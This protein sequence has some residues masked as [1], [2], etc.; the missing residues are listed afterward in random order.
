MR[1]LY[2][3]RVSFTFISLLSIAFAGQTHAVQSQRLSK[4]QI[5]PATY[6]TLAQHVTLLSLVESSVIWQDYLTILQKGSEAEKLEYI[7]KIQ[8]E[9]ARFWHD[10]NVRLPY[11]S[12]TS[13]MSE[14][15]QVYALEPAVEDYLSVQNH[16][17]RLLW[18]NQRHDWPQIQPG[19]LLR[20]GDSHKTISLISQRLWLLGDLSSRSETQYTYDN[21]IA[22]A[23]ARFQQRHGLKAD[24][25]I[26]PKTLHWIN[27]TPLQ[28][29]E[30]LASNFVEKTSYLSDLGER[31]LLVNIP[32][33]EMVLVN[34]SQ[35]ALSSRVIVGKAY[36]RTPVMQGQISNIV[37]NPTW[38]VPKKLM[39]R[40]ILP[41]VAQD[42]HYI[43]DRQFD[44]FDITGTKVNKTASEWQDI[45]STGPFP[46]RLVQRPGKINALGRYKFHFKNDLNIY[47][48]D[49]PD[50]ALFDED[51]RALSSGCIRIEKVQELAEWFAENVVIDKRTWHRMQEQGEQTQ[52]FSLSQTVPVHLVY[53]NAW[54]DETNL[55]QFRND[56][57]HLNNI[58]QTEVANNAATSL[59][60]SSR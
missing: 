37:I 40:D 59:Q 48:H 25:V 29:A 60:V 22:M 42:G 23:V 6:K 12:L 5:Q 27:Q 15:R 47:L 20:P 46:Y 53:W 24:S 7:D 21:T 38:T 13:S 9:I 44:V 11:D 34:E 31:Y 39:R 1:I 32:A 30:L 28:R 3:L 35:I 17:R 45:V 4:D 54:V 52:W 41:K 36:R 43:T 55:A 16:I 14:K 18:L 49:T 19:G 58:K 33:F 26:G 51:D 10:R 57:Y 50:K 56:I 8:Q 2:Y